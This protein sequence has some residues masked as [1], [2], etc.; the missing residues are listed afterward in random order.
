MQWPS[1]ANSTAN[2]ILINL[3]QALVVAPEMPYLDRELLERAKS[4]M[5]KPALQSVRVG[6]DTVVQVRAPMIFA[7]DATIDTFNPRPF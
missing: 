5:F 3:L 4:G 1:E 7:G 2:Q 6:I